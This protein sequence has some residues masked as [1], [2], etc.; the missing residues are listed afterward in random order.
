V[1]D[2]DERADPAAE[3]ASLA[4]AVFE[5]DTRR[6]EATIAPQVLLADADLPGVGDDAMSLSEAVRI[7]GVR[8]ITIIGLL[9]AALVM[10]GGVFNVLAPDIQKTLHI[11]DAVLGAIGG[12]TGVLFVLGAIPM[13]SLSDRMSRKQLIAITMTIWSVII[14]LTGAVQSVLQMFI[15]RLGAGLGQSA[16]LPVSAPLLIDAYPIPARGRVFAVLGGSQALGTM[17]APFLA[18]SVAALAGGGS[19]WRLPFVL[20]GLL[21]LPVALSATTIKEPRRGRY[22]MQSVLGDELPEVQDELPISL[23]VAFERLRQIKSFYYFLVGMAALGFAL[24]SAPLFLS[25]YFNHDLGLNAFQRGVVGTLIAIP[26]LIAIAISGRRA[27]ALFRKSPPAAMAFVGLLVAL[28]GVALVIAISMP[29]I[30]TTVPVLAVATACAQAAFVILPAVVSTIIPYRL[31]A[32]GTAMVG[33]YVFLFGSFFG[34]ILTGLLSDAYGPR[35]ALAIVA[36]PS[37]LIGGGLIALGARHI[38]DDM[39][40]VVEDLRE[41]SDERTRMQQP[42]A[43]LPVL[44][45]RNLDFSYG[46][47]QVLFG[48]GFDV[49]EG[50]TLA[51]LGT[52]GA[53][54][55]TLLRVIS[56]LGVPERGVVRL[57]GRTITYA[58]PELRVRVGLVQLIGG[59]ATFGPLTVH[60]NLQMAAFLYD[61]KEQTR[62]ITKSI[63]L[64]PIL[65]ERFDAAADDLSGGQQQM[66]A[67]AMTMVH[68]PELLIID[69]LSLGLAPVV[70]QQVL[71]AVQHLRD[72][73]ITMIIVEQSL[74]VALA[75]ADRALFMEKGEIRFEGST[76]ELAARDDLA[77][78][79]F[80]GR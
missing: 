15:V 80:L 43:V 44:Q 10:D 60:E 33:I 75:I 27:D 40:M 53:G 32:R 5:Q 71:G 64:F 11:S 65:Q 52:N 30:W 38:R 42:D 2:P 24:F 78:A 72:A 48:V 79:V 35:A 56:G 6:A 46:K 50:E 47:V 49:H 22:E 69:E 61:R 1:S 51:L 57:R 14:M 25:L 63:E 19:G 3:V 41:E 16:S 37:A 13:S 67:L 8:T 4:A 74:N 77:R 45:V 26:T 28:F 9:G 36:L 59:G 7:G 23:S 76:A 18:G 12:A 17:I 73:G 21:A 55:S 34:A 62:R 70:V 68:E 54:K 58:D 31:R 66:L 20:L 29:N 39:A